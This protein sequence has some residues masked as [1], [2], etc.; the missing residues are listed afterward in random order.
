MSIT[1]D[2]FYFSCFNPIYRK[3]CPKIYLL[4]L[5]I[6]LNRCASFAEKPNFS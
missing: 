3:Y 4:T 2:I 6:I 1:K 5:Y